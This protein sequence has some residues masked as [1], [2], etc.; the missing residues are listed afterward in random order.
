MPSHPEAQTHG[1]RSDAHPHG[2]HAAVADRLQEPANHA[3]HLILKVIFNNSALLPRPTTISVS[4][5]TDRKDPSSCAGGW[6]QQR[7]CAH[8]ALMGGLHSQAVTGSSSTTR[9]CVL[10][11]GRSSLVADQHHMTPI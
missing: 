1:H 2:A 4:V 7:A 11:G 3:T 9:S 10:Q 8:W 6:G 5:C